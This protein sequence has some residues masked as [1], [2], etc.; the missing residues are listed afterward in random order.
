MRAIGA[1]PSALCGLMNPTGPPRTDRHMKYSM[2]RVR[3]RATDIEPVAGVYAGDF[4]HGDACRLVMVARQSSEMPAISAAW[5]T[6][7]INSSKVELLARVRGRDE[8]S[9]AVFGPLEDAVAVVC[10][11]GMLDA[12]KGYP[13]FLQEFGKA[14][15]DE[16]RTSRISLTDASVGISVGKSR[17]DAG[18][19]AA[20]W[21]RATP[22]ERDYLAAMAEDHE[23]PSSSGEI[24]RRLN[25]EQS[26]LGPTRANL[27]AKG[28]VY[29]PEHGLIAYTVPGMPDFIRRQPTT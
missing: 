15:W 20:R 28:L 6:G 13:Y 10:A 24:A 12:A 25:K 16:A 17:L 29:A 14:S 8:T 5:Q 26:Q 4:A 27:I 11:D 3:N 19:F 22:S 23:G 9:Q 18:F 21:E 1:S 7:T 2:S